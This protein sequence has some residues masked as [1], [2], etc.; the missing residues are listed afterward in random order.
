MCRSLIMSFV[1]MLTLSAAAVPERVTPQ[2][3]KRVVALLRYDNNTGDE[4]Y[5]HLGRI[6]SDRCLSDG[7]P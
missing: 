6:G 5:E 7:R 4:Q 3:E 1:L 2:E